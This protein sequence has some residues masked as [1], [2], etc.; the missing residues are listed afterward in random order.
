MNN[1]FI[2]KISFS[3][4][5]KTKDATF[6]IECG[7]KF[8]SFLFYVINSPNGIVE[9][10]RDYFN[11]STFCFDYRYEPDFDKIFKYLKEY[12]EIL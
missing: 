9:F 2:I 4:S 3:N 1:Q 11:I 6:K 5:R 10:H 7:D 12:G 8:I